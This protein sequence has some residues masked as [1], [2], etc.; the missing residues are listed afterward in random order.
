MSQA[1]DRLPKLGSK[2]ALSGPLGLALESSLKNRLK[3][4]VEDETSSPIVLYDAEHKNNN[5]AADWYGEHAGKWLIAASRAAARTGDRA[6]ADTVLKVA[7]FLASQQ[8]PSGYLG[9][10]AEAADGRFTASPAPGVRTWDIWNHSCLILGLL[11]AHKLWPS[12]GLLEV[13]VRIVDLFDRTFVLGP[14]VTSQGNHHGLSAVI[15]LDPIVSVYM[16]TKEPKHLALAQRIADAIEAKPEL[17]ILSKA[18]AGSDSSEMGTGKAYQLLWT[19]VGIAKLYRATDEAK[20]LEAAL[21]FHQNVKAHHLTLG[22]GPW[23]GIGKHSELFNDSALFSPQGFVETCSSMAWINLNSELLEITAEP[24]FA[25]E[26]EVC[27]WNSI[28]GAIDENGHDWSYF[29]FPNGRRNSTYDWACCKS[30]GS[31]ALE[32][33]PRLAY[34]VR[35]SEVTINLYGPSE[36]TLE[37]PGSKL[38]ISQVT[39]YPISGQVKIQ[40]QSEN[41]TEFILRLRVPS[42]TEGATLEINGAAQGILEPGAY[43]SISRVWAPGD[44]IDLSLPLK[45]SVTAKAHSILHHGQEVVRNDMM[46]ATYGPLVLATGLIDGFKR[47]ETLH[48]PQL[49]PQRNYAL[50][51]TPAGLNG[52]AFELRPPARKPILFVPYYEAGGRTDGKWRLTWMQVAWQ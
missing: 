43:I 31:I 49:A 34:R 44:T 3:Q 45:L 7:R 11:E 48:M 28:L 50:V 15:A 47:D 13:A 2:V 10:Y 21:A 23:G 38:T 39:E 41:P 4:F 25:E 19:F 20:L 5:F 8:E 37:L 22:G 18:I 9:T 27:L 35:E 51:Q 6:L 33:A 26:I 32:E 1:A 36:G 16:L 29:T 24:R 14:E 46:A 52:P 40:I 30:S 42:W 17:K 12:E